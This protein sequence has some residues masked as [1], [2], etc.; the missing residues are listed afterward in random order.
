MIDHEKAVEALWELDGGQLPEG[1]LAAHLESCPDCAEEYKRIKELKA[2]LKGSAK[3]VPAELEERVMATVRAE[4]KK[5][6][7]YIPIGTISAAAVILLV[8][9]L[10]G[11]MLSGGKSFDMMSDGAPEVED[12]DRYAPESP[13]EDNIENSSPSFTDDKYDV[14]L[15]DVEQESVMST[16]PFGYVDSVVPPDSGR[17]TL[18]YTVS[19]EY[20]DKVRSILEGVEEYSSDGVTVFICEYTDSLSERIEGLS[21]GSCTRDADRPVKYFAVAVTEE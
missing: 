16:D 20:L 7:F 11:G 17:A 2:A 19:G 4:K 10:G 12:A 3:P 8:F 21:S 9:T 13:L 15:E 14:P 18:L 5:R 1:E 6:S